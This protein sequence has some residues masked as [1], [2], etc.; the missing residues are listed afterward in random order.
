[1][2]FDTINCDIVTTTNDRDAETAK[3]S[4]PA[5]PAAPSDKKRT[6][7]QQQRRLLFVTSNQTSMHRPGRPYFSLYALSPSSRMTVQRRRRRV[8]RRGWTRP[9]KR[10]VTGATLTRSSLSAAGPR[11][12]SPASDASSSPPS[13]VFFRNVGASAATS[14]SSNNYRRPE[15]SCS[16]DIPIPETSTRN[17]RPPARVLRF[18]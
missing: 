17:A 13:Y 2:I 4:R 5:A 9:R 16:S 7:H 14:A 1:M 10:V 15:N 11:P 8:M 6:S 3:I 12:A 18:V